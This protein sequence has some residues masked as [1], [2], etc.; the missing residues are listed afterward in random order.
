MAKQ[1]VIKICD[2]LIEAGILAIVFLVPVYFAFIYRD[3]SVFS[4]DKTVLF[5]ILVEVL[6]L[7]NLIKL[8]INKAILIYIRKKHLL[9]VFLFFLAFAIASI[10]S[11]D[12]HTSF[13]GSYW[14]QQG[15]FTYLHYF[16]FF[17]IVAINVNNKVKI[18]RIINAILS[19]S[20]FVAIFGIIQWLGLDNFPWH[21]R[22][23]IGG[24]VTST[25]GQPVFLGSYLILV[26]FLTI[27]KIIISKRFLTR[28]FLI[29]LFAL[30]ILCLTFTYTRGAWLSFI[31]GVLLAVFLYFLLIKKEKAA[32][33]IIKFSAA[34]L[35]IFLTFGILIN[36]N[37][38]RSF[39][40]FF[41][42]RVKSIIDFNAGS[43]AM[44]L[45]YWP[46]GLDAFS[47]SPIIGYGPENQ[48]QVLVSYYDPTWSVFETINSSPD[49]AHNELLELLLAGGIL[50]AGL[51]LWIILYIFIKGI[52]YLNKLEGQDKWLLFFLLVSFFSYQFSLLSSFSVIETSVYFWLY[53]A[54]IFIMFNN[55]Q[56]ENLLDLTRVKKIYFP[57]WMSIFL[58]SS[59]GIVYFVVYYNI[60][61]V[62]ADYYF[63]QARISFSKSDYS[64]MLNNYVLAMNLNSKEEFYPWFFVNDSLES[65]NKIKHEDYRKSVLGYIQNNLKIDEMYNSNYSEMIRQAKVLTLMGKYT[66]KKHFTEAEKIYQGL[67][68]IS[69]YMPDT[70]KSWGLMYIYA[71]NYK[72]AL[73]IY[74]TALS[75]LPDLNNAY[76]NK[77]HRNEINEYIVHIYQ[78]M[79]YCYYKL[80]NIDSQRAY[81][82]KIINIDPYKLDIY[83][84][85]ADTYYQQGD[86][87]QAIWYNKRVYMLNPKD[88]NWPLAIAL[89]YQERGDNVQALEYAEKALELAP[90]N[91]QI[92]KLRDDL[93]KNSQDI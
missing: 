17:I 32:K 49:R 30:Q 9:L 50:L 93:Q 75:M 43:L 11:I 77:E 72:K 55:Y 60:N 62:R 76:L 58:F 27:Y 57:V 1:K 4:L 34:V 20:L 46:A 36:I 45:K 6:L 16:L 39:S 52:S 14:R 51:Y 56:S 3:Y 69:P 92:K 63:R 12:P 91:E 37:P 33:I 26:V 89:L 23:P 86:L 44:R 78:N 68:K 8:A 66:D 88:Y 61:N 48:Q 5:R 70:Y 41:T 73:T 22:V 21:K 53:L 24:R 10:F 31:A 90:G 2:Y 67:V 83:K 35:V 29:L 65:L 42:S 54:I 84:N 82:Q 15:L 85:I 38:D 59:I 80:D 19:A 28:F 74:N 47:Q 13:W 25:I 64:N 40:K 79:A 18:E 71:E 81:Y 87:S 7:L